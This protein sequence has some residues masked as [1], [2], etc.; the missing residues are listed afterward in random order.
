MPT[1]T[2]D[3]VEYDVDSM[4]EE[5][6]GNLKSIQFVDG[7]LARLNAQISVLTTARMAYSSALQSQLI[8]D[9]DGEEAVDS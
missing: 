8:E 9:F 7:E 6:L 3:D 2:I 1:I 4:S 5:A